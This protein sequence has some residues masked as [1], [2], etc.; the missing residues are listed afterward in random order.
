[1]LIMMLMFNMIFMSLW[2]TV[3]PCHDQHDD[4]AD[5]AD[6]VH[7]DATD[8]ADFQDDVHVDTDVSVD[9]CHEYAYADVQ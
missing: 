2:V 9:P 4:D 3:D 7:E 1:M 8:D 5:D 6:D